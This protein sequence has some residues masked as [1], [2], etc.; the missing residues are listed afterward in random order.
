VRWPRPSHL[1]VRLTTGAFIFNSGYSK[2]GADEATA[3]Q[4]HGFASGTYPPLKGVPPSKFVR[5]LST[6]EMVLGAALMVPVVPS[7]VVGA[8]L[9]AFSAGLVGMY[10]KTPGMRME[11]SLRPTQEGLSLAKDV[12]LLGIGASLV[13]D[14]LLERRHP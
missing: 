4:L 3:G 14:D 11:K 10:L 9:A 1:P 6:G 13:L 8:G 7:V 5:L 12:W 2:R